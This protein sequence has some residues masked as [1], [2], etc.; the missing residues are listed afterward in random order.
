M[1]VIEL[2]F[3]SVLEVLG[4]P[5]V[6]AKSSNELSAGSCVCSIL[7][8][9]WGIAFNTTSVGKGTSSVYLGILVASG[10]SSITYPLS[11]SEN[12]S[13]LNST[14]D[15]AN[16]GSWSSSFI[17]CIIYSLAE[18][19]TICPS[20]S[21]SIIAQILCVAGALVKALATVTLVAL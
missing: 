14:A 10:T 20:E 4:C 11:T 12:L 19:W 8:L 1:F 3:V 5:Q 6:I 13:L 9:W 18:P 2:P 16:I 7:S 21:I 15:I 17:F